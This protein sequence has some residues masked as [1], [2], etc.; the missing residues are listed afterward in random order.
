MKKLMLSC[1]AS[2]AVGLSAF[3]EVPG[4]LL[5]PGYNRDGMIDPVDFER[6]R[7]GEAFTIWINDDD[8]AAGAEADDGKGDTNSDL[9]DVPGGN[10]KKDCADD[11]VNGRCDLL[12]FFP[13]LVDVKFVDNWR[14]M[15]WKLCSDSV[16]VVFTGLKADN[17]GSFHTNDVDDNDGTSLHEA[18]VA[19]LT[20]D[21]VALPSVFLDEAG[22]GVFV[23]EGRKRG[24]RCLTLRGYK[25]DEVVA[26]VTMN[27]DVENVESLYGWMNLRGSQ[28]STFQPS[29]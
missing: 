21:G 25:Y 13:V 22:E 8:D 23:I 2:C 11:Q 18:S 12:D 15:T 19:K 7:V 20:E 1:F 14:N 9:H 24:Q 5:V 3:A 27:L 26:E 4:P 6:E 17:A 10:D 16:N 29:T 28:P